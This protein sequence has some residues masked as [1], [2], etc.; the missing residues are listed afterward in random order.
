MICLFLVRSELLFVIQTNSS[1]IMTGECI[2]NILS[3][4]WGTVI[5]TII[6][7]YI[8][9][10]KLYLTCVLLCFVCGFFKVSRC[11]TYKKLQIIVG[12]SGTCRQCRQIRHL[13]QLQSCPV[14]SIRIILHSVSNVLPLLIPRRRH[15]DFFFFCITRT[16]SFSKNGVSCTIT[17]KKYYRLQRKE[18]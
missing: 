8:S 7:L 14:A 18:L 4:W 16:V 10:V 17:L 6:D 9:Y 15:T 12:N 1:P 3:T 2:L 11:S 13:S 5:D